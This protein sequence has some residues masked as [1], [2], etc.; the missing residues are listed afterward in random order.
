MNQTSIRDLVLKTVGVF[1]VA[2]GCLSVAAPAFACSPA[3]R[4]TATLDMTDAPDC[5]VFQGADGWSDLVVF[6]NECETP[7]TL[8][9][10]DCSERCELELPAGE[11]G[12][13]GVDFPVDV[14]TPETLVVAAT[15]DS[16]E[17]ATFDLTVVT[18]YEEDYDPCAGCSV[19]GS[20]S[21]T[22]LLPLLI[23]FVP[24]VRTRRRAWSD[25]EQ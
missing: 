18:N 20:G 23:A 15:S 5:L 12:S 24:L 17:D 10:E 4:Q 2:A 3:D 19:A 8:T 1:I 13:I 14:D 16:F 6:S 11:Q 21:P 22:S 25:E 7:V 9:S